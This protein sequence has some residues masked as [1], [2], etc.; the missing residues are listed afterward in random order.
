MD[1]E[2]RTAFWKTLT[3]LDGKD[4]AG[5]S[6]KLQATIAYPSHFYRFR[7]VSI[8]A[9]DAMQHNKLFFSSADY[10]DDPFDS[11]LHIDENRVRTEIQTLFQS[12]DMLQSSFKNAASFWGISEEARDKVA[13]LCT[14]DN[15]P[16]IALQLL[17]FLQPIPEF[18]Q[19]EILSI[20]FCDKWQNEQLWLKY[21]E[22]H[23]GF[24]LE[25]DSADDKAFLCGKQECCKECCQRS[26][27]CPIYPVY[28]TDIPFDATIFA[29]NVAINKMTE[30]ILPDKIQQV[31]Q[32]FPL[33][34]WDKEK[35]SLAKRRCHE[36]D[37]EWRMLYAGEY[38]QSPT[39]KRPFICWRPSSVTLGLKTNPSAKNLI[40]TLSKLAGIPVVY[41]CYVEHEKLERRV[42]SRL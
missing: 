14:L 25:Y 20:C 28:Y 42:V 29:R 33:A 34:V 7:G 24:V 26:I 32:L 9:L 6:R 17:H 35:I 15:A 19:K 38:V 21:A 23:T 8:S 10:Y 12:S 1:T 39:S 22:N 36:H 40:I 16:N 31:R 18:V 37:N 5:D 27:A 11:F 4:L 13:S 30:L 2:K 3:A 41:E